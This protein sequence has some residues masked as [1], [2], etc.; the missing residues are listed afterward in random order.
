MPVCNM[1]LAAGL[2]MPFT[3]NLIKENLQEG[4]LVV[5]AYE[6]THWNSFDENLQPEVVMA[7]CDSRPSLLRYVERSSRV[8]LLRY[9]PTYAFKKMNSY[10][11][12]SIVGAGVNQSAAYNRDG[13]LIY[14]RSEC[15][16]PDPV[17]VQVAIHS[18]ISPEF[19]AFINDFC[20]YA[21]DQGAQVVVSVPP[22]F[23]EALTSSPEEIQAFESALGEAIDCPIISNVSDYI[24]PRSLMYDTVYHCNEEGAKERTLLLAAD[25]KNYL[26][27]ALP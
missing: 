15:V 25:I 27:V 5:L 7:A 17:N 18:N 14:P 1:A 20:S 23:D 10:F 21:Q 6:Y 3:T 4:D 8:K 24:F 22:L 2:G 9:F 16:L 13:D 19:A 12:D 26:L 11:F